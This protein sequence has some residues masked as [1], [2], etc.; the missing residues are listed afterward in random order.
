MTES[1][2]KLY[3]NPYKYTCLP[4]GET[5]RGYSIVKIGEEEFRYD[6][7]LKMYKPFSVRR[8]V[9]HYAFCKPGDE[10]RRSQHCDRWWGSVEET[11]KAI[12][13]VIDEKEIILTNEEKTR[14]IYAPSRANHWG[15]N[16]RMLRNIIRA[17]CNPKTT[18][19]RR[20][21]YEEW[22]TQCNYHTFRS[23]LAQKK[24]DAC[25]TWIA[26]NFKD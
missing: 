25:E 2:Q 4:T 8:L 9:V 19:S 16:A 13:K 21:G 12:D 6:I 3:K 23:L 10:T 17:H 14:W 24:Y 11:K 5:Y 15:F 26:E 20:L 1:M 22:L 7:S 18:P